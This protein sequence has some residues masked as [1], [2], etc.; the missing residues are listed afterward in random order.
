[1]SCRILHC[2][3]LEDQPRI[4]PPQLRS[5]RSVVNFD[6][7]LGEEIIEIDLA[8][9]HTLLNTVHDTYIT[10]PYHYSGV[11]SLK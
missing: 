7:I 2:Y 1:M 8:H 5:I 4:P 6:G 10:S 3:L 11:P 9:T